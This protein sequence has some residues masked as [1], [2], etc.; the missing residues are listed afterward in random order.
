MNLEDLK[1]SISEMDD[2]ELYAEIGASR[3]NRRE[4]VAAKPKEA[5]PKAKKK[6]AKK[7][8]PALDIAS[9]TPEQAAALL[10]KLTGNNAKG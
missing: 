5:K 10:A 2:D 9:L 8:E 7:T 1:K 3:N 4:A 6:E